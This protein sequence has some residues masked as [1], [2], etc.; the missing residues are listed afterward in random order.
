MLKSEG[1]A[2]EEITDVIITHAHHD[3]IG[4]VGCQKNARVFIQRDEYESG[5][6][7]I[8]NT[9]EV[10]LF[11]DGVTVCDGV[12]TVKIGGHS[13]GSSRVEAEQDG[14]IYV[15]AGD[16]CYSSYNLEHKIPTATSG[17]RKNSEE[18]IKT[19]TSPK[20]KVLL[21]H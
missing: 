9:A 4:C 3:H 2:P 14:E 21:I 7:Y 12:R 20:Y 10:I 6:N 13:K 19:Y 17:N 16:E 15:I 11:D 1:V 18:F 5:K 8:R